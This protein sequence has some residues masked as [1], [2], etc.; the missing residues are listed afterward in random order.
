MSAIAWLAKL[1]QLCGFSFRFEE[2]MTNKPH[3]VGEKVG[4]L[5]WSAANPGAPQGYHL[6]VAAW[7]QKDVVLQRPKNGT[8]GFSIVAIIGGKDQDPVCVDLVHEGT[9]AEKAG[10]VQGDYIV[11]INGKRVKDHAQAVDLIK[12]C[13][14]R[15]TLTVK[16]S[17]YGGP[18]S[19]PQIANPPALGFPPYSSNGY[20]A[21]NATLGPLQPSVNVAR[22]L[23]HQ[24]PFLGAGITGQPV[25]NEQQRLA[26]L[27]LSL[28]KGKRFVEHK[29]AELARYYSPSVAVELANAEE[30]VHELQ[31]KYDQMVYKLGSL[32]LEAQTQLSAPAIRPQSAYEGT[33]S[34]APRN[35]GLNNLVRDDCTSKLDVSDR[36]TISKDADSPTHETQGT[37]PLA[38][39]ANGNADLVTDSSSTSL[40]QASPGVVC[41]GQ[42][43]QPNIISMD[44]DDFS[45]KTNLPMKADSSLKS[46]NKKMVSKSTSLRELFQKKIRQKRNQT[47]PNLPA[48]FSSEMD[49]DDRSSC[50]GNSVGSS[51]SS[52][53]TIL[54]GSKQ[55]DIGL[56]SQ[57]SGS[58][59]SL[60][61]VSAPAGQVST[62]CDSD[63]EADANPADWIGNLSADVVEKM[64]TKEKQRQQVINELF[65]TERSHV[66][67]LKVLERVFYR[68]L[69]DK[70]FTDLVEVLF[71]NLPEMLEI[72]GRFNAMMKRRRRDQRVVET[73]GDILLA[74]FDGPSGEQFQHAAATFCKNQSDALG[75]LSERRKKNP[76]LHALLTKAEMNP[77]CRR[78][79]LKDILPTAMQRLTKYPLLLD[80]LAKCTE[81][82][83]E[84]MA[85]VGRSLEL[86]REILN[87]VNQA[88]KDADNYKRLAKI[89]RRLD[90]SALEKVGHPI[91]DELKNFELTKHRLVHE[92]PLTWRKKVGKNVNLHVVLLEEYILLLQKQE[93]KYVLKFHSINLDSKEK[94]T[95]SPLV[96]VAKVLARQV[97]TEKLALFLINDSPNGA[98]IYDL[99]A[100]SAAESKAWCQY[101]TEAS[102][103]HK[104]RN[105]S[106]SPAHESAT[107]TEILENAEEDELIYENLPNE[108]A[109]SS[110]AIWIDNL[111][112]TEYGDS[113][114][115]STNQQNQSDLETAQV[116]EA[117]EIAEGMPIINTV[118]VAVSQEDDDL[119]SEMESLA[120]VAGEVEVETYSRHLVMAAMAKANSLS[121]LLNETLRIIE[122]ES[123]AAVVS[124]PSRDLTA[125]ASALSEAMPCPSRRAICILGVSI[126]KLLTISEALTAN[127]SQLLVLQERALSRS[128]SHDYFSDYEMTEEEDEFSNSNASEIS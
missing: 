52:L 49:C 97:A 65:H 50:T 120:N 126:S 31:V 57:F 8:F 11:K 43:T 33:Q 22:E 35:D 24:P 16:S 30:S 61:T 23:Q 20:A 45:D 3:G 36:Q 99:V 64:T 40:S 41:N 17:V 13:K 87:K 44:E 80:S 101:I 111:P 106:P 37:R 73:V 28:E 51:K 32:M 58:V 117:A 67:N 10:I 122:E 19:M 59:S 115:H 114:V 107:S 68:P 72:H 55:S 21:P 25:W 14:S 66:R 4:E 12:A 88:I 95:H 34:E 100:A 123:T 70:R 91:A 128:S 29:R 93:D 1:E 42:E 77:L 39:N 79:Q 119:S 47:D 103:A 38:E 83:S 102:E 89:E 9:A 82:Q 7:R 5:N 85:S 94:F 84:E 60:G 6:Q 27:K 105:A 76:K 26:E 90:K 109:V 75:T 125:S 96:K 63:I 124:D 74:M 62:L 121:G 116:E 53:S 108:P 112:Q 110:A 15:V 78:L 104:A 127:L 71:V 86:S 48:S 118:E 2:N 54:G 56:A 81:P 46:P 69:L 92:G 18:I 113:D 98:Q